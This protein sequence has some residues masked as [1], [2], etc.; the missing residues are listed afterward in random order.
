MVPPYRAGVSSWHGVSEVFRKQGV[1]WLLSSTS[2]PGAP[3][4]LPISV[5][6]KEQML[7]K[8]DMSRDHGIPPAIPHQ[9]RLD[10]T[11]LKKFLFPQ[12]VP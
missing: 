6:D 1:P 2:A 11:A 10:V 7:A 9:S 4:L 8:G 3:P 5:T 12:L